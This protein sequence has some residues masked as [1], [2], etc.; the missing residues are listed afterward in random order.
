MWAA[1]TLPWRP[2]PAAVPAAMPCALRGSSSWP[3]SSTRQGQL[4]LMR[5]HF[6]D[7]PRKEATWL[8]VTFQRFEF[9]NV[10]NKSLPPFT[11]LY[12]AS[13]LRARRRHSR[14]P[15]P[16]VA[17]RTSLV[18]T[19]EMGGG[20]A[21][22]NTDQKAWFAARAAVLMGL[23]MVSTLIA[24]RVGDPVPLIAGMKRTGSPIGWLGAL[25]ACL[26]FGS[27]TLLS[28]LSSFTRVD[29]ATRGGLYAAFNALGSSTLNLSF[30]WVLRQNGLLSGT[31][32]GLPY[33]VFGA[34]IISIVLTCCFMG[35]QKVGAACTVAV[36]ASTG[37]CI[38]F[39]WGIFVFHES[40]R[41]VAAAALA[42]LVLALGA[43]LC[44]VANT[45]L[46]L[47]WG[48]GVASEEGEGIGN[49]EQSVALATGIAFAFFGGLCDGTLMVPF[50]LFCKSAGTTTKS[51][52]FKYMEA[53]GFGQG[54]CF[55]VMFLFQI[56]FWRQRNS[57]FNG[58][59]EAV[60][61]CAAPGMVTGMLWAI[62]N[63]GSIHATE[64]L[65]VALGFPLTQT[66]I[67]VHA[68]VGILLFGEMPHSAQRRT[69]GVAVLTI[70]LGAACLAW[71]GS[72]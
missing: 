60:R 29:A 55:I 64:F 19:L 13:G 47:R 54:L 52:T 27:T 16:R 59:R 9:R 70:L 35:C 45:Q 62:A 37:M 68:F 11:L 40:L 66:N 51:L 57:S 61:V 6:R 39:L 17:S 42:L 4:L 46:P 32:T 72:S 33:G 7:Q 49:K 71:A 48:R 15:R 50:K 56:V 18:E 23:A 5:G 58:F 25:T 26:V 38:S 28:K 8:G 20:V 67:I 14:R 3:T 36:L 21:T 63:V 22:D 2:L 34:S 44:S 65:G 43:S 1:S 69:C 12:A 41:S 24:L 10:L 53:F 31:V 30:A